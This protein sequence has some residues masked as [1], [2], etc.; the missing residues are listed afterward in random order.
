VSDLAQ[1]RNTTLG[2]LLVERGLDPCC[3]VAT[4]NDLDPRDA[5]DDFRDIADVVGANVHHLLDRMQDGP[6]I[7]DGSAV[8]SFVAIGDRRARLTSFRRFRMRRPGMA[9]GDIVYDYDAA[10]LLHA[11]I[12]RSDHPYFYDV[13]DEDG[14]ADVIGHLIVEWPD[15]GLDATVLADCAALRLAC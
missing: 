8:L 4:Y 6:R 9:P 12:A 2:G 15:D 14:M 1:H 5:C 7:A 10:H 13:S 11:F 3:I